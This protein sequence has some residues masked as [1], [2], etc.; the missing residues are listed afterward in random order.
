MK[1][2]LGNRLG[3]EIL[4]SLSVSIPLVMVQLIE[5]VYSLTDTYFVSGL[6]KEALAGVGIAGYITWLIGVLVAVFQAPIG[7]L[8]AQLMGAGKRDEAARVSGCIVL[9][10][11]VY[12]LV[13]S[14][15]AYTVAGLIVYV[16]S[17]A[18]GLVYDN[19]VRYLEIRLL[20]FP[21]LSLAMM[22]DS[23]IVSTGKTK[24]SMLGHAIGASA[25][26]VLDPLLIYG[27]YG[28]P[29]L[30]VAGAALATVIASSLTI[31]VQFLVLKKLDLVPRPELRLD[32]MRKSAVLGVPVLAERAVMALSNNVYAG[33]IARL[34][35][36]A[37]A[38]HNIGLRIESIVYMPGF[39]FMM[40]ASTL[41]GHRV[42][43]GDLDSARRIG[44]KVIH[45]GA[46]VMAFI[47]VV[48]ALVGYYIVAPFSPSEDV[49][50]LASLYLMLAGLSE[51]GLG[52]AMVS[53]GAIRGAGETKVPFIVNALSMIAVRVVP[54]IFLARYLGA[55]GP[56]LAMFLDVYARGLALYTIFRARFKRLARRL[57]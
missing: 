45:L 23:I 49:R 50:V 54:A 33:V 1:N 57:T 26:I 22:L 53:S 21:V 51:L 20:G 29:K 9:V 16:Q 13:I 31:P 39:A 4:E 42:G 28:F 5:S 34:G 15:L 7:I 32:V 41:V 38:A 12:S 36:T 10:G 55:A 3:G 8:T 17:G 43:R 14:L 37:M 6:G 11:S 56:W 46:G 18:T 19:A 47:G 52:L 2:A 44:L 25:N 48:I 30:E 27:L 40:T 24:Y 35:E